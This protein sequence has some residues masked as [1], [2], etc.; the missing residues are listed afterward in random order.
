MG[1]P[2]AMFH[3]ERA[4]ESGKPPRQARL[5][6]QGAALSLPGES[7]HGGTGSTTTSE[8][9]TPSLSLFCPAKAPPYLGVRVSPCPGT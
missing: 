7:K 3:T 9:T 2:D 8:P 1:P 6:S 5:G 4:S